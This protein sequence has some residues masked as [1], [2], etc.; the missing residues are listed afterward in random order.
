[1]HWGFLPGMEVVPGTY[2]VKLRAGSWR[3]TQPIRVE[4]NPN[5]KTTVAE[6]EKQRDLGAEVAATLDALFAGLGRL[7]EIKT[8]SSEIVERLKKAGIEAQEVAEAAKALSDKLT[9][10]EEKMTQVK[11]KSSQ[12]P[13]NFP[14]MVDN[15]L[16]T[17]YA[18]VVAFPYQPTEGAYRRFRDLKPQVDD[19]LGQLEAVVKGELER[20]NQLVRGKNLPAVVV[21]KPT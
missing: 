19:L 4:V 5:L 7:R 18:Y 10:I 11:S 12:D 16:A 3:Q 1:V 13:I 20:F 21:R 15:Q 6:F 2:Q 14:A 9:A 17:L 8:Q